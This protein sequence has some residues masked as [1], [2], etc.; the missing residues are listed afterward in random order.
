MMMDLT[1]GRCGSMLSAQPQRDTATYLTRYTCQISGR[2]VRARRA[3]RF[4]SPAVCGRPAE[5]DTRREA[6]P[7]AS[8]ETL[9]VRQ[10][11]VPAFDTDWRFK[12]L[13]NGDYSTFVDWTGANLE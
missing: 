7:G 6:W 1:V 11:G 12:P 2:A 10:S 9:S 13:P 8:G 5:A 4:G 3:A